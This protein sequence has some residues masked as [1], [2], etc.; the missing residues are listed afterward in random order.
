MAMKKFLKDLLLIAALVFL[1]GETAVRVTGLFPKPVERQVKAGNYLPVPFQEGRMVKGKLKE[2][3][4]K[5]RFNNLGFN[6][7]KDYVLPA[8]NHLGTTVAIVGDSFIEGTHVD[9]DSSIGRLLEFELPGVLVYEFGVSETNIYDYNN[10]YDQFGL[11]E[12]DYVFVVFSRAD[13]YGEGPTSIGI[14]Q[15]IAQQKNQVLRKLY[16]LSSL[17]GFINFN[18]ASF[19]TLKASVKAKFF[20]GSE[21]VLPPIHAHFFKEGHTNLIP[22]FNDTY[23]MSRTDDFDFPYRIIRNSPSAH[24]FG[25]DRHWNAEGRKEVARQLADFIRSSER[26]PKSDK[27]TISIRGAKKQKSREQ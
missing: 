15:R 20:A 7:L 2:I 26:G 22:V 12:F 18:H 10:I 25:F 13:L 6:S 19:R 1:L 14:S 16:D 21:E 5:Y 11:S 8:Q 23:G 3:D 24:T 9:V 4:A 17:I 27:P